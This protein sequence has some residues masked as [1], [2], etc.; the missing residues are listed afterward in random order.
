MLRPVDAEERCSV[1]RSF[2]ESEV[3]LVLEGSNS[4]LAVVLPL[5]DPLK[6]IVVV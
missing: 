6:R 1:F 2:L 5:C 3:F 4:P